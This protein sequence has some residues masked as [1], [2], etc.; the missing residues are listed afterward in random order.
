MKIAVVGAGWAGMAAA[1]AAC[2]AGHGVTVLEASRTLGGR[3]RGVQATLP[4][5]TPVTLDNG[6]HILIGAYTETL[7]LMRLVGVNPDTTLLRRPLALPFVDGSGLQTPAYATHWPAPLDAIAAIATARGWNWGE[8]WSL[9]R[10]SLGW[11]WAGF[12]CDAHLSV[13]QLCHKL[14]P[15]VLHE[16]IEPLCVS[17][18][19]TPADQASASVFLRVLRDA[20]F[21]IRGG[22]HLLLPQTD[23]STLFPSAAANWITQRGGAVHLGHRVN[24]LRHQADHWLLDGQAFDRVVWASSASNA[25]LALVEC[26]QAAPETIATSLQSWATT[27]AAL[28]VEAIATV[29]AWAP[30]A[31][32]PHP[33]LALRAAPEA[34]AQFVFDRGQ[35]GGPAGLLAFVVSANTGS[36]EAIQTAVLAQ[37]AQQLQSLG[38]GSLQM[39]Q[40]VV[41]KQ[42][43]FACTPALHRPPQSIAPDLLAAGDYVDGPYPATLEGAVR[44]GWAAGRLP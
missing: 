25:A 6:Q 16:L 3:A 26:A 27:T 28:R 14:A 29:Y 4:D 41:E 15:R 11:Q 34:P 10:A 32:L 20:L 44:S 8:R 2:E 35:L 24:Q 7:R 33:M 12:T 19:N 36:R 42:A 17:A 31:R 1:V 40:T 43:T 18:L 37:A 38:L 30:Q 23:L 39:V 5:G 22:S 9:I 13:A 21:G